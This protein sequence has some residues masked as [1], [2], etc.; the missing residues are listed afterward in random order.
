M[1]D[2]FEHFITAFWASIGTAAAGGVVWLVRTI[3]TNQKALRDLRHEIEV[4]EATR[5]VEREM[6]SEMHTDV[7]EIRAKQSELYERISRGGL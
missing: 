4:R 5:A 6:W 1:F 7:K 2:R 3:F